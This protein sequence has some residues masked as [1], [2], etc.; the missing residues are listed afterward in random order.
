MIRASSISRVTRSAC[1]RRTIRNL[2]ISFC[3]ATGLGSDAA[4]LL[5]IQKGFDVTTLSRAAVENYAKLTGRADVKALL[6]GDAY[7]KFSADRQLVD[8]FETY[9]EKLTR[10]SAARIAAAVAGPAL[11]G[12]V[13]PE[14][15]SG[16]SASV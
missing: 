9:S 6:D 12:R 5:K 14:G 8:L 16:R 4:L 10:R 11:F 7:A 15:A 3:S 13:E 1:C 2:S